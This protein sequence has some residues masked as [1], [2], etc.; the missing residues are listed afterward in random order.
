MKRF[1][2]V[3]LAIFLVFLMLASINLNLVSNDSILEE[4]SEKMNSLGY[5]TEEAFV[6]SQLEM[7]GDSVNYMEESVIDIAVD[8]SGDMIIA[9]MIKWSTHVENISINGLTIEKTSS[10]SRDIAIIKIN[11]NNGTWM[12]AKTGGPVYAHSTLK[13][14]NGRIAIDGMDNIYL[15]GDFRSTATFGTHSITSNG[16]E[17]GFIAQID[18][19]G[20]WQ[21]ARSIG[22]WMYD[23]VNDVAGHPSGGAVVVGKIQNDVVVF[24]PD[25]L[26][27]TSNSYNLGYL[28]SISENGDWLW[29][30]G[31]GDSGY[32]YAKNVDI[33]SNGDIIVSGEF[34]DT[35]TLD[36]FSA[37]EGSTNQGEHIFV[38]KY[39]E[40]TLPEDGWQYLATGGGV[41]GAIVTDI[42]ID[43]QNKVIV[44]GLFEG[45]AEF[46]NY[47]LS[48]CNYTTTTTSDIMILSLTSNGVWDSA[49]MMGRCGDDNAVKI[50]IDPADNVLVVGHTQTSGYV[51][52]NGTVYGATQG[53][54]STDIFLA[55]LDND[56]YWK[57]LTLTGGTGTDR[58][59]G[60][61]VDDNGN[62]TVVGVTTSS[63]WEVDGITHV[64]NGGYDGFILNM[65]PPD[66]DKDDI[67]DYYDNDDDNDLL[68][69]VVDD[70][71]QG[72]IG[73]YSNAATDYDS[74]GCRDNGVEDNDDD[75]DGVPDNYDHCPKGDLGWLSSWNTDFDSDGCQDSV[76]DTDDDNDGVNDISDLCATYDGYLTSDFDGDGCDDSDEDVDDD[77]DGVEDYN[78]Q[79]STADF[80]LTSDF[81]GDGCDDDDEDWDDDN[82]GVND[83]YDN[84]LTGDF[85]LY[86]DQDG[87]GCDDS[88]EDTDDDNDG[89][90]D[91][92]DAFPLDPSE[93]TDTDEDGVGDNADNDDDGDDVW[94]VI[95]AFPLDPAE[96]SDNDNDGIG[97]NADIDDDNDGVEDSSDAFPFD[98]SEDTD[99]DEDGVGDN[100]D[101]DDDNDGITDSNDDL[102]K[103]PDEDTDTDNDGIG[104]NADT[105]DDNDG[106]EDSLDIFPLDPTENSDFDGDGMGDNLD[107]DDDND[108]VLDSNDAYPLNPNRTSDSDSDG[109]G[110][111][112]DFDDCPNT[113]VGELTD[114]VGCHVEV[115]LDD[116]ETDDSEESSIPGFTFLMSFSAILVR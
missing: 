54:S 9:M 18:T 99:T 23:Y 79:C 41:D 102:P 46:G 94:D 57:W 76:E 37:V 83:A 112:D 70:C 115:D 6:A 108:G 34:S 59:P 106:F 22:G 32:N 95:D 31:I 91:S 8:S 4:E 111:F 104:D 101:D 38:A 53:T 24:G 39:S 2:R 97:D 92:S 114:N 61:F 69:A 16:Q 80:S 29:A 89:V 51:T 55:K 14:F 11:G 27:S 44:S 85:T 19:S 103:N 28:A 73:W 40:G 17:D 63:D 48:A 3:T 67:S 81:D 1:D 77:N 47:N 5:Q 13:L 88:D 45:Y 113:P 66:H 71:P 78:D 109:D 96:S 98:S 74:D 21:W 72:D 60:I 49:N 10:S 82:D 93:D 110:I 15:A 62:A 12:W 105:D 25:T 100:A 42:A 86:S 20:N 52:M 87:D 26:E 107:T 65:N 36:S 43:S 75:N 35:L 33:D 58:Y 64:T 90:E 50:A 56:G 7:L 68:Y 116:V 30:E 84:C